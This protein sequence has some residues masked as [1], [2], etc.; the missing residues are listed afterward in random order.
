VESPVSSGVPMIDGPLRTGS[1]VMRI[2]P[3]LIGIYPGRRR[4]AVS[5]LFPV[6]QDA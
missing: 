1:C 4:A 6:M 2:L 5:I 3:G